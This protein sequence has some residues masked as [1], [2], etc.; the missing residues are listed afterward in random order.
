MEG[1]GLALFP[2]LRGRAMLVIRDFEDL[3]KYLATRLQMARGQEA[4]TNKKIGTQAVGMI[5]AFEEAIKA[6]DALASHWQ[7]KVVKGTV[8]D[9]MDQLSKLDPS[10][11]LCGYAHDESCCL[12]SG[13]SE[14]QEADVWHDS[15][16]KGADYLRMEFQH[17]VKTREN[18]HEP[19][20]GDAGEEAA[21]G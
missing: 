19:R 8:G 4:T 15:L 9:A 20:A 1:I 2:T 6:V 18:V 5:Y 21:S 17:V 12:F 13:F 10:L 16:P 7:E 3:R 11:F 14:P